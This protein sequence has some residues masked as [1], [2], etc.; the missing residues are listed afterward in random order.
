[1]D[2]DPSA[3]T[4]PLSNSDSLSLGFPTYSHKAASSRGYIGREDSQLSRAASLSSEEL[5]LPSFNLEDFTIEPFT[6][7]MSEDITTDF[8]QLT[9]DLPAPSEASCVAGSQV[10]ETPEVSAPS[11]HSMSASLH[12]E[13]LQA[14]CSVDQLPSEPVDNVAVK[15][16]LTI[17]AS[18]SLCLLSTASDPCLASPTTPTL[19]QSVC[20]SS[21]ETEDSSPT[22]DNGEHNDSPVLPVIKNGEGGILFPE[23]IVEGSEHD[24]DIDAFHSPPSPS[25]LTVIPRT[26]EDGRAATPQRTPHTLLS[27][28]RSTRSTLSSTPSSALSKSTSMVNLRRKLSLFGQTRPPSTVLHIDTPRSPPPSPLLVQMY[29]QTALSAEASRITDDEARRLSELAFMT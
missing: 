5:V 16:K 2:A 9:P 8:P 28:L 27:R 15:T 13:Y 29:D 7:G 10:A 4:S 20:Y 12:L 25:L 21:S 1:M 23:T 11:R 24:D 14:V 19:S 3:S 22:T 17:P 26:I 6:R 18:P